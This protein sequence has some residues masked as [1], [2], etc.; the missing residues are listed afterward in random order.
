MSAA[1]EFAAAREVAADAAV[2]SVA[3]VEG[4]SDQAAV[5]SL[6]RRQSRDLSAEGVRVVSL[7]GATS[8]GTF[9][10]LFGGRPG[11]RIVGLC[12]QAEERYFARALERA[13]LG[14][15]LDRDDLAARGFFVCEPDLEGELIRALGVDL[16]EAVIAEA[17]ELGLLRM[18]QRQPAQ[19]DRPAVAQLHRFMGTRSGRKIEYA[20]RLTE[21]LDLQAVPEPLLGLLDAALRV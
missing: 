13:H 18:F 2:R 19:Q 9:L 20:R 5:E 15:D 21:A 10:D 16:V 8:I 3:L 6:A 12:D 17:D 11:L 1:P 7:G 4:P 14:H